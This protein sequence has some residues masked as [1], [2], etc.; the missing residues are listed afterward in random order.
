MRTPP[1]RTQSHL[2]IGQ[3][4]VIFSMAK[5][6]LTPQSQSEFVVRILNR[7]DVYEG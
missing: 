2:D 4:R 1:L 3:Y 5:V 6:I 7:R